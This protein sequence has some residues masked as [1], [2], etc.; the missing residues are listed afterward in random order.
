[1]LQ[2]ALQHG[3]DFAE[4]FCEERSGLGL[5]IDESRVERV[6]RGS[7]RG[8]GVRV[9][10]GETSYFGHVDGLGEGELERAA[11]AVAAA[12]RGDR[13][14]VQAL[15]AAES[16]ALQEI[17]VAPGE[18]PPERKAELLRACDETARS[19]GDAIAQVQASYAEGSRR[20]TVANSEG[21][22]AADDRTRVRLGVQVVARRNGAVET[23]FET[24]S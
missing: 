5:A 7:E 21:R 20:V 18:V 11:T 1:M 15:A 12:A 24:E 14:D 4:V 13:R 9:V 23:G 6:Q 17:A 3:G 2:R 19:A 16:P 22:F 10:R 8:A